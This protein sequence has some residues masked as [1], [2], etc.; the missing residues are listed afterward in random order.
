MNMDIKKK[1]TLPKQAKVDGYEG[2]RLANSYHGGDAAKGML[3]SPPFTIERRRINFL[4]GSGIWPKS[5]GAHQFGAHPT[6]R[7]VRERSHK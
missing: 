2:K 6:P 7:C 1:G 4:I 5:T 3:R